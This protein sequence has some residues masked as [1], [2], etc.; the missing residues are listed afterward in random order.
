V[1]KAHPTSRLATDR[2]VPNRRP[3]A[4]AT[5]GSGTVDGRWPLTHVSFELSHS[6]EK[7]VAATRTCLP[8]QRISLHLSIQ[9]GRERLGAEVS[10]KL[11]SG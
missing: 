6:R 2:G 8:S 11:E 1:K 5:A 10:T 7:A 3:L 9:V 4:S